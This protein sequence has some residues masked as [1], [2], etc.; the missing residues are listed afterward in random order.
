MISLSAASIAVGLVMVAGRIPGLLRPDWFREQ[1]VKFP[2]SVV[3]GRVLLALAAV[4]VE[5]V[6]LNAS[7]DEWAWA[8]PWIAVGIPVGYFLVIK[9]ADAYLSMRAAAALILLLCRVLVGAADRAETPLRLIVTTL[10]Y[11]WVL[12]ALWM[13]I[14]PH[15]IRDVIGFLMKDNT[16]CRLTCGVSVAVGVVLILLGVLVY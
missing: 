15:H 16:R 4:I 10:S 6:M 11:V 3:W 2:R 12:L 14:A 8:R 7:L 5:I 13:A 9:Y 1:A